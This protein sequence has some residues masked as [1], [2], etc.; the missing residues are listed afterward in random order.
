MQEAQLREHDGEQDVKRAQA[1]DGHDV[2]GVGQERLA[3][4]AEHGGDGVEG[5]DDV[6][7]FDCREREEENGG[8]PA[9]AFAHEEAVLAVADGR[10][11]G[12]PANPAG[13]FGAIGFC[14]GH[15]EA[16]GGDEQDCAEDVVN[17]GEGF[18]QFYASGDEGAAHD[19]GSGDSPEEDLGLADVGDSEEAKEQKED[20]EVIDGERFFDGVAGEVLH[21]AFGVEAWHE[22][23]SQGERGGDPKDG[24]VDGF[25]AWLGE[26]LV[27]AE[28]G[29]EEHDDGDVEPEPIGEWGQ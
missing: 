8:H 10:E 28:L 27:E 20:E 13:G 21:G 25:A 16:D 17:P 7:D 26:E 12:E 24:C 14:G 1:H 15:D 19:D 5:E 3:R 6:G 23:R 18:E 2:R 9:T 4:N 22:N 11:P 29:G